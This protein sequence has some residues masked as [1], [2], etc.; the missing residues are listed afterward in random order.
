MKG[1]TL[2]SKICSEVKQRGNALADFLGTW[3]GRQK[4]QLKYRRTPYRQIRCHSQWG[5]RL[6]G[7]PNTAARLVGWRRV[8][9][10]SV[11]DGRSVPYRLPRQVLPSCD[12]MEFP[13]DVIQEMYT[14]IRH[15]KPMW[16]IVEAT[17]WVWS[18]TLPNT[19]RGSRWP[20]YSPCRPPPLT[21]LHPLNPLQMGESSLSAGP[22]GKPCTERIHMQPKRKERDVAIVNV[23]AFA[24]E[25][26]V[27]PALTAKNLVPRMLS[28]RGNV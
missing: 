8:C 14:T 19:A 6:E 1:L 10:D 9:D 22:Q 28:H 24:E 2:L 26:V 17:H 27:K 16:S 25:W 23:F 15:E 5:R 20:S 13:A 18:R 4:I 21:L 12:L 3:V 11:Y 7:W